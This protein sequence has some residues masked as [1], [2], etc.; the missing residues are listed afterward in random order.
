MTALA[1]VSQP[2]PASWQLPLEAASPKKQQEK[3]QS[4]S[5]SQNETSSSLQSSAVKTAVAAASTQ[6]DDVTTLDGAKSVKDDIKRA[7]VCDV[8]GNDDVS[9]KAMVESGLDM[10]KE[11]DHE[12]RMRKDLD[13]LDLQGIVYDYSTSI[14]FVHPYEIWGNFLSVIASNVG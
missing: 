2:P 11:D 10:L 8:M 3:Q 5:S 14:F 6:N 13:I 4:N 7:K 12:R 9:T 1:E